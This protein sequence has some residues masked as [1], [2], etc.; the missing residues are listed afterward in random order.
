MNTDRRHTL[1]KLEFEKLER[2]RTEDHDPE[3]VLRFEDICQVMELAGGYQPGDLE[4]LCSMYRIEISLTDKGRE[5]IVTLKTQAGDQI[6]TRLCACGCGQQL[7]G[8]GKRRFATDA[9]K[10]RFYRAAHQG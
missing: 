6:V 10:Q 4:W 5:E 9:C 2:L 1:M 8:N 7:V 3:H